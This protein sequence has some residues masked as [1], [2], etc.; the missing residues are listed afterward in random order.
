MLAILLAERPGPLFRRGG[1]GDASYVFHVDQA[2][3]RVLGRGLRERRSAVGTIGATGAKVV[4]GQA[5]L[6]AAADVQRAVTSS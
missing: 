5:V 1:R 2:R 3:P 4:A 6:V